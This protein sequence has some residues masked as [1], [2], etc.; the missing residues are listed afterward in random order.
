MR[1]PA[2][3]F[4]SIV[5]ALATFLLGLAVVATAP[6]TAAPPG[7]KPSGHERPEARTTQ[8]IRA[9]AASA[10]RIATQT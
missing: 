5:A 10:S 7:A 1:L 4:M 2:R 9:A 8:A 3:A 6:A